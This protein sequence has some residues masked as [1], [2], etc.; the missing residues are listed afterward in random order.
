VKYKSIKDFAEAMRNN[1]L[2]TTAIVSIDNSSVYIY[3]EDF[4][5][6]DDTPEILYKESVEAKYFLINLLQEFGIEEIL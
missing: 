1:Q 6:S 5:D 4:K 2:P 3:A